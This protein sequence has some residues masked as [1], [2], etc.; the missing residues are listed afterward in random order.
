MDK[1]NTKIGTA[2]NAEPFSK[3]E[4]HALCCEILYSFDV[5]ST[6]IDSYEL[7]TDLHYRNCVHGT[8]YIHIHIHFCCR[9][10]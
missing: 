1:I 10:T 2:V 5:T 7:I 8:I 4:I 9:Y 3:H 6:E